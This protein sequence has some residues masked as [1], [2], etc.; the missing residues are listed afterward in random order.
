MFTK[1]VSEFF[2][3][4]TIVTMLADEKFSAT[5]SPKKKILPKNSLKINQ[6]QP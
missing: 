6:S 1:W 5:S 4:F 2:T 3:N